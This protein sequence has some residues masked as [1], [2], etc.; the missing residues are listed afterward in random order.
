[1]TWVQKNFTTAHNLLILHKTILSIVRIRPFS[2]K[3]II[4]LFIIIFV[5]SKSRLQK[6]SEDVCECAC[7]YYYLNVS[8]QR[9]KCVTVIIIIIIFNLAQYACWD[10]IIIIHR[11]IGYH[12]MPIGVLQCKKYWVEIKYTREIFWFVLI[13]LRIDYQ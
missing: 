9:N 8:A 5:L 12:E 6:I 11:C 3:E 10:I 4:L 13:L 7:E 1:M 2:A